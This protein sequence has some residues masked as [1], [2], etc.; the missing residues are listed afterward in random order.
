MIF[1]NY[2]ENTVNL[3]IR[4]YI[5]EIENRVTFK[6]KTGYYLEISTPEIMKLLGNTK[7]KITKDENGE[8]VPYLDI[9]EVVLIACNVVNNS[10]QQNSRVLHTFV[11]RKSFGQLLDISPK[12]FIFLITFDSKFL[13]IEVW[14][15]DQN[16]NPLEIED[17][18][19]IT[20]VI[21]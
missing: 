20:L 9:T 7:S 12:N 18:I 13:Y 16:S 2:G 15:T 6:I 4:I 8:N 11:P 19:N 21:N 14:F 17:K 5:N 3:S 10:Y 1:N